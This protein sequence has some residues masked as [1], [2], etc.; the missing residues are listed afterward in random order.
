MHPAV[1]QSQLQRDRILL[2]ART[3]EADVADAQAD[4][5]RRAADTARG[6]S[7]QARSAADQSRLRAEA[8]TRR[9]GSLEAQLAELKARPT[10]R[11]MVLT[12]GD[13]LFESG[14]STLKPG[15]L[16]TV[17]QLAG[18]LTKNPTRKVSIEGHA[19]SQGSNEYNQALSTQRSDNVRLALIARHV[20]AEQVTSSGEGEGF[21]VASNDN[22]AG[23]LQNRRVEVVFSDD[24]GAIAPRRR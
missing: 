4:E 20:P 5:A 10:E 16:R 23:R 21:P 7:E 24:N 18:F 14:Q 6:D 15:A 13:V 2:N 1:A 22:A 12:L 17:D 9:A 8:A 11:G 3:R 19:D